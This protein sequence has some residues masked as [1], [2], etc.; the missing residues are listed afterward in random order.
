MKNASLPI[1]LIVI[2]SVWLLKS[3]D[4]MPDVYWLWIIGLAGA[5]AAILAL[6]GFTKSSVVAGPLLMLAGL[7]A[8]FHQF[9]GLGW[10]YMVPTMMLTAGVLM[11]VARSTSIPESRHFN[12]RGD[13]RRESEKPHV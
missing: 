12:R 10:R 4:W 13:A 9:H 11:L 1:V 2:G 7:L 5:G 6:D 3:L 8:Y